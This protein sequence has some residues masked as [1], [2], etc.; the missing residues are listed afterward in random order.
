MKMKKKTFREELYN[1]SESRRR[2]RRVALA[3]DN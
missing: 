3:S 2:Y 1:G